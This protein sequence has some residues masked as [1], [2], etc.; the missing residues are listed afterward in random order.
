MAL[1]EVKDLT[2]RFGGLVAVDNVNF[3][4]ERGR[5]LGI[6]GPNG[7]G[8]TTLYNLITGVL[9]PT[10]GKI[11]FKGQD[12]NHFS[13]HRRA[14]KGLVRTFQT[15]SLFYE[16]TCLQ[17]V[18][19]A[20]HLFRR[21]G[22]LAQFAKT[23][24]FRKEDKEVKKRAEEI[25]GYLGLSELKDELAKNLPHGYQR[26]LG[27]ALSLAADPELLLLDEP[28]TG[29]NEAETTTMI[30]MIKGIQDNM[31]V[32]IVVVEHDMR[33]VMGL[34]EY[35]IVLNFGKKIAEG[36]PAEVVKNED[37]IEAYLGTEEVE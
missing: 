17:N 7:A 22:D 20:H 13:T 21:S 14:S 34:S 28:V 26:A 35:V 19:V 25:L 5:I 30:N 6:I 15:T 10:R 33:A 1:L 18:L 36:T 9:R 27:I 8:K 32:S 24:G 16:M 2:K 4:M 31:G 11:I 23:P 12:V 3:A 29:M 37:V